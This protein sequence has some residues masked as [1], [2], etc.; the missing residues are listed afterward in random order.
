MT[1][2]VPEISSTSLGIVMGWLVRYFIRRFEKFTPAVLSSIVSILV[3]G[4]AVKFLGA[5]R[6]VLSFYPIGLLLGF[7]IYHVI[8]TI[9]IHKQQGQASEAAPKP[10]A[11]PAAASGGGGGGY[12][13]DKNQP[14]YAPRRDD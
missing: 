9:E 8:A 3:G 11:K 13:S 6:N 1:N 5:D 12:Y 10:A 14:L 4:V 2:I 7:V